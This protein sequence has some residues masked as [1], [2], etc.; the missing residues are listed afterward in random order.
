MYFHI[1]LVAHRLNLPTCMVFPQSLI[2]VDVHE[3][4]KYIV[5]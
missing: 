3:D 2:D 4:T 1:G 5:A